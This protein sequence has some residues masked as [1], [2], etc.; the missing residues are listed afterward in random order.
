M[1]HLINIA[2]GSIVP[3]IILSVYCKGILGLTMFFSRNK[4]RGSGEAL[5]TVEREECVI[6]RG[7]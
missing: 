3:L 7:P 4:L 6:S 5:S 1:L 2:F